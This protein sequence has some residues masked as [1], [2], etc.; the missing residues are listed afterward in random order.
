MADKPKMDF[1]KLK[2]RKPT[3]TQEKKPRQQ[4]VYKE[5]IQPGENDRVGE[6]KAAK[7]PKKPGR[8]TWK[9]PGVEYRR[10]SFSLREETIR[11]IKTL[12]ATKFYDKVSAQDE[13]VDLALSEFIKKHS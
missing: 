10:L 3:K 7:E 12:L 6:S 1:T 9:E 4:K 8:K 13:L 5:V 2:P 11:Q